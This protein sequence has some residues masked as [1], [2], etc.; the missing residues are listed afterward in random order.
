LTQRVRGR[1]LALLVA[2]ALP[3]TG[4]AA[5]GGD[6]VDVD[7]PRTTPELTLPEGD[8]SPDQAG[9]QTDTTGTGTTGTQTA[10]TETTP[11]DTTPTETTPTDT[12]P[13]ETTP[14]DTTQT[15]P[16]AAQQ[17]AAGGSE[18]AGFCEENPGAC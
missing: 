13:T 4:L 14:T 1:S 8:L 10:P 6:D 5:C 12:T 16:P 2:L 3:V 18:L 17:G 9:G 7:R 15:A 11:T